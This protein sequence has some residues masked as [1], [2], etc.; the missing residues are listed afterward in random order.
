MST[1]SSP[2]EPDPQQAEAPHITATSREVVS[3]P[4]SLQN[5]RGAGNAV[6]AS[7]TVASSDTAIEDAGDHSDIGFAGLA[8]H[9]VQN[10]LMNLVSNHTDEAQACI[11]QLSQSIW[12]AG[13]A[14]HDVPDTAPEKEALVDRQARRLTQ[15]YGVADGLGR[16]HARPQCRA[17]DVHMVNRLANK[18]LDDSF[19]KDGKLWLAHQ[20]VSD[21]SYLS[22][23]MPPIEMWSRGLA[24]SAPKV[25]RIASH[26]SDLSHSTKYKWWVS[27]GLAHV[28]AAVIRLMVFA[29]MVVSFAVKKLGR[30]DPQM[31]VVLYVV[32]ILWCNLVPMCISRSLDTQIL[33]A[34]TMAGVVV[35]VF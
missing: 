12:E 16:A 23:P 11:Q 26:K 4:S 27:P 17:G 19:R 1:S 34:A 20:D 25:L 10:K 8:R 2:E 32:C 9:M 6:N 7:A 29:P 21:Y 24:Q 28:G 30:L 3:P 13:Q 15:L 33:L 35:E 31:E 5:R 14:L 18:I 22:G